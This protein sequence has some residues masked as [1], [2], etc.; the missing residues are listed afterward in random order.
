MPSLCRV[1]CFHIPA[2]PLPKRELFSGSLTKIFERTNESNQLR[3]RPT[4]WFQTYGFGFVSSAYHGTGATDRAKCGWLNVNCTTAGQVDRL[5]LL[6]VGVEVRIPDD[7]GLLTALTYL[8]SSVNALTGTIPSSLGLLVALKYLA[9]VN[10]YLTGTIPSSLG[11]L[12]ALKYLALVNDYLTGTIP[13]SF[14]L[15][16][17]L[18]ALDLRYHVQHE[19]IICRFCRRLWRSELLLLH[20]LLTCPTGQGTLM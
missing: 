4:L 9:L 2:T 6:H 7:F 19:S 14:G 3:L 1:D 8:D 5:D 16:T 15:F 10:D 12:T 20:R 13:S 11:L 18:T 17:A